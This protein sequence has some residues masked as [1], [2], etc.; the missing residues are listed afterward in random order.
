MPVATS[1]SAARDAVI[2]SVDSKLAEDVRLSPMNAGTTDP[3]RPQIVIAAVLR[4]GD[5]KA[6]PLDVAGARSLHSRIAAGKAALYIDRTKYPGVALVKGDAIRAIS[7]PGN[8]K[9]EVASVDD[10]YHA[11]LIVH[12]NQA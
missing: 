6:G 1:F 11:R 5:Q 4:T 12:L 9:F 8:P 7:R 3:A 10:R 2:S